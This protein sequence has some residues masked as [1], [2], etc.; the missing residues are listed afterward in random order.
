MA[1]VASRLVLSSTI[2]ADTYKVGPHGERSRCAL[3]WSS[4]RLLKPYPFWRALCPRPARIV[5]PRDGEPLALRTIKSHGDE[6]VVEDGWV[7]TTCSPWSRGAEVHGFDL[8]F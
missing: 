7:R 5:Q 1:D 2:N 3:L 4:A 8:G 6:L